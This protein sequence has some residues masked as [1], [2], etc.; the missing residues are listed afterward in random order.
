[1][2]IEIESSNEEELHQTITNSVINRIVYEFFETHLNMAEVKKQ[3][4]ERIQDEAN[5][6][7]EGLIDRVFSE[8]IQPID[9]YGKP[10]GP[11]ISLQDRMVELMENYLDEKV[12]SSGKVSRSCGYDKDLC[13]RAEWLAKEISQRVCGASLE[14]KINKT[15]KELETK[16]HDKVVQHY[17]KKLKLIFDKASEE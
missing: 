4:N 13:T 10:K 1:M 17:A 6:K 5:K 16:L 2:R 12:D 9:S 11:P 3:I 15:V 8:I 7:M 14:T